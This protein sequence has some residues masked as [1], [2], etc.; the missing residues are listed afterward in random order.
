MGGCLFLP[1]AKR[2]VKS[3]I[4]ETAFVIPAQ[5]GIHISLWIPA[6]RFRGDKFTPALSRCR[7]DSE[8]RSFIL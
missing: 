1:P 4:T 2:Q 5:A 3:K 8:D 7:D 6:L